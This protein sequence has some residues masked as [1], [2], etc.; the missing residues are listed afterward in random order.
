MGANA[1]IIFTVLSAAT[2]AIGAMQKGSADQQAAQYQ[3]AVARN[4]Q[5]I[6]NQN[7]QYAIEKGR[8]AEEVKRERTA[9][10][11]SSQRMR[12]GAAGLT[13]DSGSPLRIQEDV[14]QQ[15]E[16]DALTI[17]NN[18]AR[19]AYG[20]ES[21]GMGYAAQAQLDEMRGRSARE[22][23]TLGAFSSIVGGASSVSDK[24]MKFKQ[25]GLTPFS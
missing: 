13:L 12:A 21:Q 8:A 15:G 10:M 4:N 6:A 14:A 2:S 23:G 17:R 9:Q 11:I 20:W 7:A 19:E 24:W 1:S 5:I 3:A 16:I 25:A 22:A 18:A